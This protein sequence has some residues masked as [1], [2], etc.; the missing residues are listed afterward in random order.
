MKSDAP[1]SAIKVRTRERIKF[2]EWN[3]VVMSYDGSG[4][5]RGLAIYV[6]GERLAV[7]VVQDALTGS[8]RTDAP[9]TLGRGGTLGPPFHRSDRRSS[10]L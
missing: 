1:P 2:G 10:A 9:L 8:I 7:D 3:H 4:K 6:N 5:A